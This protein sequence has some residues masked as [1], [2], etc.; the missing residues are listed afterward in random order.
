MHSR[1]VFF[2]QDLLIFTC[3]CV[4]EHMCVTWT[5]DMPGRVYKKKKKCKTHPDFGETPGKKVWQVCETPFFFIC[6]QRTLFMHKDRLFSCENNKGSTSCTNVPADH[7]GLGSS[8]WSLGDQAPAYQGKLPVV[9]LL[10]IS[11]WIRPKLVNTSYLLLKKLRGW[12]LQRKND[13]IL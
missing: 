1:S 6:L 8:T 3:V 2:G 11:E 10:V 9:P 13:R 4:H 5:G 7:G 12:N